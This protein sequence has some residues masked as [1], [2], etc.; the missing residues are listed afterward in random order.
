[1]L[2]SGRVKLN[3]HFLTFKP[4]KK[5]PKTPVVLLFFMFCLSRLST[6]AEPFQ[7]FWREVFLDLAWSV[8]LPGGFLRWLVDDFF[9]SGKTQF[10]RAFFLIPLRYFVVFWPTPSPNTVKTILGGG[11]SNMFFMFF[12][13]LFWGRWSNLTCPYFSNG[14]FKKNT[15]QRGYRV[16]PNHFPY[17]KKVTTHPWSTPVRQSP[18]PTMKGFPKNNL[19]VKVARGVF[20]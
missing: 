16:I 2:V 12:S 7:H 18:Y 6:I 10:R 19:L 4:R 13:P 9:T 15:N 1:M 3:C 14:W 11:N 20:Q 8:Q 17:S 5:T